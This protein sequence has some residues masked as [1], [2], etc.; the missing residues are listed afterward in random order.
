MF[1]GLHSCLCK[2]P[3]AQLFVALL[4]AAACTVQ[5]PWARR[6]AARHSRPAAQPSPVG[7]SLPRSCNAC[8]SYLGE[9]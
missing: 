5:N 6:M 3:R 1:E 2:P 4:K 9:G 7:L 8:I